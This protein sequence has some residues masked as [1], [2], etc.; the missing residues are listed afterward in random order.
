MKRD[1]DF[2]N[3]NLYIKEGKIYCKQKT[4]LEFPKWYED[5]DLAS[6]QEVAYVYGI[7]AL[8][9]GDSYSVSV[10]PT[11]VPTVPI[12]VNEIERDGIIY[13]QFVYGKD[14]CIIDDIKVV[15]HDI[16]SY[17]FFESFF[18]YAKIPWY[19]EYEDIVKIMDNLVP[20]AKSNVGD[21]MI[22][23]ELVTS[24]IARSSK[25]KKLFYRQVGTGQYEFINL[26]SPYYAP[27]NTLNRL[28]GNYM[29]DSIVSAIVEK[30]DNTTKLEGHV[31]Q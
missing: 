29:T 4:I 10:I 6:I 23:S 8:I 21:N 16:L 25:D 19:V 7:F 30:S 14:D 26:L 13:T 15:K 18:M 28:A 24:F 31:R 17:N 22:A 12:M 3:K 2:I 1:K 11:L 27:R 20:Y 5:K 9:I